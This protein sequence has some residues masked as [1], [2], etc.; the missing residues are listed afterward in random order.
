MQLS[1]ALSGKPQYSIKQIKPRIV[2]AVSDAIRRYNTPIREAWLVYNFNFMDSNLT[3]A[4]FTLVVA[5]VSI[6]WTKA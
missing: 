3:A 2:G 6:Q 1:Q 5:I 4:V